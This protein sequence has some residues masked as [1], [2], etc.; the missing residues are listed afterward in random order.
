M[1][2]RKIFFTALFIGFGAGILYMN[3]F[4]AEYLTVLGVFNSYY[5]QDFLESDLLIYEYLARVLWIRIIPLV[6]MLVL[7]HLRLNK[8]C[9]I[10]L[11]IW[12]GF[13]FG[14]YISLGI[15][16][17]GV[18]GIVFCVLGIFPQMLF[19]IPAYLIGVVTAYN[20]PM[21]QF[22]REKIGAIVL[23]ILVGVAL[24]CQVNPIIIKWYIN[25][26]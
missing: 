8:A 11:F 17:L 7:S 12:T 15:L 4:A 20:Y 21:A 2:K 13:L 22:G 25:L 1:S 19:Y 18:K 26:I 3:R 9:V 5:L 10:I 23:L 14:L 16:Q 24:E 6:S